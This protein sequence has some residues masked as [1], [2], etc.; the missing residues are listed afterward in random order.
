MPAN[1]QQCLNDSIIDT[2]RSHGEITGYSPLGFPHCCLGK[3][4]FTLFYQPPRTF[5]GILLSHVKREQM[6][7]SVLEAGMD[8]R[9]EEEWRLEKKD[10]P[11]ERG[12]AHRHWSRKRKDT[13]Q[14]PRVCG[15]LA[16]KCHFQPSVS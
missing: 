12:E 14:R 2:E 8:G 1:N 15:G 7:C 4:R 5:R 6:R 3:A 9:E 11:E 10:S 16:R 13:H